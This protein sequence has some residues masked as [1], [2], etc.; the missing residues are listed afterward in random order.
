MHKK[1]FAPYLAIIIVGFVVIAGVI[2]FALRKQISVNNPNDGSITQSS[3]A[4]YTLLDDD[5]LLIQYGKFPNVIFQTHPEIVA[6]FKALYGK[7]TE[8]D[9]DVSS[10]AEVVDFGKGIKMLLLQG[11]FPHACEGSYEMG[12]YDP[13]STEAYVMTPNGY[14]GKRGTVAEKF[15]LENYSKASLLPAVEWATYTNAQFGSYQISYPVDAPPIAFIDE[16]GNP[17]RCALIRH[18]V[19]YI[20]INNGAS[21]PCSGSTGIGIGDKRITESIMLGGKKYDAVGFVTSDASLSFI[22]FQLSD[23]ILVTY[24]IYTNGAP[25]SDADYQASMLDVKSILS[26]LKL[27]N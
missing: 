5:P 2:Y 27:I 11:C 3:T 19:G 26:T 23:K 15:L 16:G 10:G 7:F 24:G 14:F 1:V 18:G 13:R 4:S 12:L 25:M 9:M 21:L 22:S 20:K 17:S 6:A 8:N